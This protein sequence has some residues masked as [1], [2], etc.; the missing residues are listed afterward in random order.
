M[1]YTFP[2]RVYEGSENFPSTTD[3]GNC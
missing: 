3:T 2:R 1:N